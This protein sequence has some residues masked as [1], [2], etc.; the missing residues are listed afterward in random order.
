MG[1]REDNVALTK[2]RFDNKSLDSAVRI[3][4]RHKYLYIN[5]SIIKY[6]HNK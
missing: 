1:R 5:V 4:R 3:V 2:S 6:P